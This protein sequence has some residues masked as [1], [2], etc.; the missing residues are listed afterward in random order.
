MF[1]DNA[2]VI[3]ETVRNI[4]HPAKKP[5]TRR[6]L[7]VDDEWLMRWS[8]VET[9]SQRGYEV[10][11]A[12]DARSAMQAIDREAVDLVLLDLRLPDADDLGLLTR[13]RQKIPATPVVLMTAFPTREVVE[14]AT[15]LGA[16]VAIKPFD[17]DDLFC[18]IERT[19]NRHAC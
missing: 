6:I 8:I 18:E 19:L 15:A 14:E 3:A 16:L 13:I 7:V 10:I 12:G 5:A 1:L 4:Q 17:L 11:E 9:L 2:P